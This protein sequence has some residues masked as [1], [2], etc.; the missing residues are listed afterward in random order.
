MDELTRQLGILEN[1]QLVRRLGDPDLAYQFKHVLAQETTYQ[2]MLVKRRRDIHLRVAQ[3][4]EQL[5]AE[6]P[7]NNAATLA[8]HYFEA[9][10][11]GRTF[12]Y[13]LIAGDL[14]ARLYAHAE[15]LM[16]YDRAIEMLS[17]MSGTPEEA[18]LSGAEISSLY[19]NRGR[20][21]ELS[22]R[23]DLASENYVE[24][25]TAGR[26]QGNP[27]LELAGMTSRAILLSTYTPE[28]DPVQGNE[29]NARI[30]ARAQEIGDRA[31]EAKI[32]WIMLL[33]SKYSE[34]NLD[35]AIEHGERSLALARE[36]GLR[37]LIAY[38]L[39]DIAAPYGMTTRFAES[40]AALHEA[41]EIW[42]DLGNLAM[43][44]DTTANLIQVDYYAGDLEGAAQASAEALR[45]SQMTGSLW[46]QA[47]SQMWV[48]PL[49]AE[50]G[51]YGRA[52]R[53]ME[54]C[55]EIAQAAN[56]LPPQV[57][58]RID[59]A[60]L[61]GE[62]GMLEQALREAKSAT[63]LLEGI[64]PF[65]IFVLTVQLRLSLLSGDLKAAERI[66]DQELLRAE[67][68]FKGDPDGMLR[69]ALAEAE[70]ALARGDY[71]RAL[72]TLEPAIEFFETHHI[73][74]YLP[75]VLYLKGMIL[76][77]Q[78]DIES[79]LSTL[80]QAQRKAETLPSRRMLWR[81]LAAQS[82]IERERG[83]IWIAQA[84]RARA[85]EVVDYISDRLGSTARQSSFL[86]LPQ[87]RSLFQEE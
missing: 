49:F 80:A 73:V 33:L 68:P 69:I 24:M 57:A 7:G 11:L 66:S 76:Q 45:L 56:F 78:G 4:Y 27:G 82:K 59:Y 52:L 84:Q 43:L 34:G 51:D 54:E 3:Y 71:A 46:G 6:A 85:R 17:R 5:F 39:N 86:A 37:E 13:A 44:S 15:A 35:H 87:V 18:G 1:T 60:W 28:F 29:L 61:L 23:Y 31:V 58:T 65:S 55:L 19:T 64:P 10:D 9:G 40:R 62:L 14:A 63:G 41:I 48:G 79:A 81:I 30:L 42:K 83:N 16:Y 32:L 75:E 2:S 38:T 72:A 25:E 53:V 77:A 36:L 26:A 8:H 74:P 67:S 20:V 70:L 50:Q 22:N 47:Y 12:H 21:F